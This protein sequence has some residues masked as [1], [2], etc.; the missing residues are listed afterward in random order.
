MNHEDLKVFLFKAL[1]LF[2]YLQ[3]NSAMQASPS[4]SSKAFYKAA[5]SAFLCLDALTSDLLPA[6]GDTSEDDP[7]QLLQREVS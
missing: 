4:D 6:S 1:M 2:L 7:L 5:W 3:R